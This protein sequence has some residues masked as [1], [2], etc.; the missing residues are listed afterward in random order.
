MIRIMKLMPELEGQELANVAAIVEEMTDEEAQTFA[1][2]YRARRKDAQTVLI[3]AI[4]GLFS[5]AGLQRFYVNQIGI[6]ILYLFTAGLCF[7]GTI[8]DIVNYKQL[9][10]EYNAKMAKEALAAMKYIK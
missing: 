1:H 8:V 10:A 9:A 3:L 6:G 2:I 4:V 5:V 7:I